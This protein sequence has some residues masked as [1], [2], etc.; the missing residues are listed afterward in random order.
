MVKHF[1]NERVS[2]SNRR[3]VDPIDVPVEGG[4]VPYEIYTYTKRNI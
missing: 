1:Y 3:T 2:L 4:D